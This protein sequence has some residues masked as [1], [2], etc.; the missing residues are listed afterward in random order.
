MGK[1]FWIFLAITV[2]LVSLSVFDFKF[3]AHQSEKKSAHSKIFLEDLKTKAKK[4]QLT[5]NVGEEKITIEKRDD[6]WWVTSPILELA[7]QASIDSWLQELNNQSFEREFLPS[8]ESPIDFSFYGLQN[9]EQLP[10]I[11]IELSDAKSVSLKL[12]QIKNYE[13]KVYLK[14]YPQADRVWLVSSQM[15]SHF[16][17]KIFDFRERRLFTKAPDFKQ[18]ELKTSNSAVK[19]ALNEA[20]QWQVVGE[21]YKL[22]QNKVRDFLYLL[23]GQSILAYVGETVVRN[24]GYRAISLIVYDQQGDRT[25]YFMEQVKGEYL[26][27]IS[28]LNKTV[29]ISQVDFTKFK[30]LQLSTLRDRREPFTFSSSDIEA[31]K[32]SQ[33]PQAIEVKKEGSQWVL[34]AANSTAASPADWVSTL[35]DQLSV[36]T[37]EEFSEGLKFKQSSTQSTATLDFQGKGTASAFKFEF[38][39]PQE[40][41]VGPM[42]KKLVAV[43]SSLFESLVFISEADFNKLELGAKLSPK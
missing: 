27:W 37:V 40:I 17:K 33:G 12:G 41:K 6:G 20:K 25:E 23:T 2:G 11:E 36:L 30:D 26:V 35:L 34:G 29:R 14:P 15:E 38:Y 16:L 31:I 13:S 4:I 22:D 10:A 21:K 32:L 28:G 9:P 24:P 1:S 43:K 42:N 19:L 5:S 18:V 39:A 3:E 8:K 7:D